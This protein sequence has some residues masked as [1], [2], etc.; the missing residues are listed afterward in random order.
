MPARP[1]IRPDDRRLGP[2]PSRR[3]ERAPQSVLTESAVRWLRQQRAEGATITE[4]AE[5]LG[6]SRRCVSMVLSGR[7]WSWLT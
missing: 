2:K 7:S 4:I 5:F 1:A 6:V 3:G